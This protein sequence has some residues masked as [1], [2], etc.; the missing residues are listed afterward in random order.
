MLA[1][2]LEY[3]M[4]SLPD[5]NFSNSEALQHDVK[6]LFQKYRSSGE[7]SLNLIDAL[8]EEAQKF[9]STKQFQQFQQIRLKD[10]HQEDYQQSSYRVVSEFSTFML[11]LKQEL[12]AYRIQRKLGETSEKN[13]YSVLPTLPKN[14]LEAE[15]QLLQLQ[16]QKLEELSLEQYS[17]LSA[18]IVYKLQLEVLLRWWSFNEEVGFHIFQQSLKTA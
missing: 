6:S 10:I 17:N 5:L 2:N 1:G 8:H 18:L 16:W 9:L 14:P 15:L 12:K 4:S 3:I 11:Q 7:A 13:N